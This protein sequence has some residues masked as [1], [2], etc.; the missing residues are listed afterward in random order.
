[1][2][3]FCFARR[4]VCLGVVHLGGSFSRVSRNVSVEG[5]GLFHV[6][7]SMTCKSGIWLRHQ[8][9]FRVA[10]DDVGSADSKGGN[11]KGLF[12][13]QEGDDWARMRLV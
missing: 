1:M 5:L 7:F 12:G 8:E 10:Q 9:D 6:N 3:S 2:L 13:I 11:K 4:V